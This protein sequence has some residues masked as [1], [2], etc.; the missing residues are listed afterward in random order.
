MKKL[1][2]SASRRTDIPAF[3]LQWFITAIKNGNI[4]VQNPFYKKQYYQI[5]LSPGVVE[6]IVFWSRNYSVFLKHHTFFSDYQLFFHF[7][8]LSHHPLLEKLAIPLEKAIVQAE[9]LVKIYQSERITWRY[10]PIVIW[11][12]NKQI[13]TNFNKKEFKFLCR[14]FAQMG[15]KRCYFSFVTKYMKFERRFYRK[16]P[17]LQLELNN[18]LLQ[19]DILSIMQDS[20]AENNTKL[21]S[22]CNDTL[23]R[24]GIEKGSC[25]SGS[26]LNRLTGYPSVSEAK[27]P[28]R[29]YCGCT[30]SFDIGSYSPQPCRFGC[31]YCYANPAL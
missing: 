6:W 20:A 16:Y 13:K 22:C 3:Y 25:I 31:I 29:Q 19:N 7:T 28:T 10:D 5:N 8:V 23:L 2:I 11:H 15:I 26:Y 18:T 27:A 30:R 21:Y 12:D 9:K 14:H 24:T 1:V 4:S 17:N